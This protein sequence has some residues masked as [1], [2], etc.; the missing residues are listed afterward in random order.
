MSPRILVV[1]AGAVGGYFGARLAQAG[2][3]VTF[4]VRHKRLPPCLMARRSHA[5]S[6]R[7]VAGSRRPGVTSPR[8]PSASRLWARS[9]RRALPSPRRCTGTCTRA[10]KGNRHHPARGGCR[11][12]SRLCHRTLEELTSSTAC[13]DVMPGTATS[14]SLLSD[15]KG[16]KHEPSPSGPRLWPSDS[17]SAMYRKVLASEEDLRRA[18]VLGIDLNEK[19][20]TGS[21]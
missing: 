16:D 15:P 14:S 18:C 9:P 10:E 21:G 6:S 7:L 5:R 2:R 4:L 19:I 13:A 8:P 1:G 12:A 17:S 3:D 11:Q 20:K